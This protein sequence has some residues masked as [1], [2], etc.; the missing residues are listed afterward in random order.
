MLR[1]NRLQISGQRLALSIVKFDPQATRQEKN[2]PTQT[3]G[4]KTGDPSYG[5]ASFFCSSRFPESATN[6][7][8]KHFNRCQCGLSQVGFLVGSTLSRDDPKEDASSIVASPQTEK[9][10]ELLYTPRPFLLIYYS[11]T[12][13]FFHQ[14]EASLT[15]HVNAGMTVQLLDRP[16]VSCL[17]VHML[18]AFMFMKALHTC[19]YYVQHSSSRFK[20]VIFCTCFLFP[21]V[22]LIVGK[23]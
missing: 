10:N 11:D 1:V 21:F 19:S 8:M 14:V 3:K 18:D 5:G 20:F 16:K 15:A 23:T 12:A 2:N 7:S 6:E 17:F 4:Q 9:K 22:P 13:T